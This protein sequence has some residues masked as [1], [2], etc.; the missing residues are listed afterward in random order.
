MGAYNYNIIISNIFFNF[1]H[2]P[3]KMHLKVNDSEENL[4]F[5]KMAH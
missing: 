1:C 3:A 5:L 4:F 2:I